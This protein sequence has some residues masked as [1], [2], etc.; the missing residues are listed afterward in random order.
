[1]QV[2]NFRRAVALIVA[3]AALT[4]FSFVPYNIYA[5]GFIG[6]VPAFYVFEHFSTSR[7]QTLLLWLIWTLLLNLIGYHWIMHTIAVY[8]MMPTFVAF[9]LFLLYSLGTGGKMLLFFFF[10]RW[11]YRRSDVYKR[12]NNGFDGRIAPL[13]CEFVARVCGIRGLYQVEFVGA[14]N[15]IFVC[16]LR[17]HTKT[18]EFFSRSKVGQTGCK[19]Q[20][21]RLHLWH[22]RK[23][24]DAI[25]ELVR[26]ACR[27]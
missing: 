8:G 14:D 25:I 9:P 1:M 24:R 21:F 10:L 2:T 22:Y 18:Y 26:I 17:R 4:S 12:Q 16:L 7:R 27:V 5:L 13:V 20:F 6:L 15:K 3:S 19:T 23:L 11:M